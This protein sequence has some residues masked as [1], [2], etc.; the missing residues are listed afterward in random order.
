MISTLT[1]RRLAKLGLTQDQM[2]EVLGIVAEAG[3][4]FEARREND[5]VRKQ[6]SRT[7]NVTG[8]SRDIHVTPS[9]DSHV[10]KPAARRSRVKE[11]NLANEMF[12]FAADPET[13]FMSRDTK[14]GPHILTSLSAK[15]DS[16]EEERKKE[17]LS[18]VVARA[19][20][21]ATDFGAFWKIYPHKVDKPAALKA[22]QKARE[23]AS[24]E[25]LIEGVQLYMKTKKEDL[26]WCNPATWLNGERWNDK[27]MEHNNGRGRSALTAAD[28][29]LGQFGGREAAARYV[30]GSA[31]PKPLGVD[32]GHGTPTP[33]LVSSR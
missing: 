20:Q 32:H 4:A 28:E 8:Q 3:A 22:F 33:K 17:S 2:T 24:L 31:G 29:L 1:L 15:K 14:N 11:R 13:A 30:P 5:R 12:D 7:V 25:R 21:L 9:R 10:T 27:P 18:V 23:K 6:R 16:I 26:S 19:T